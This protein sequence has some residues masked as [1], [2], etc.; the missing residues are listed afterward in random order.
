MSTSDTPSTKYS[1]I[2]WNDIDRDTARK[3]I[4]E[5]IEKQGIDMKRVREI[6]R[7]SQQTDSFNVWY[8]DTTKHSEIVLTTPPTPAEPEKQVTEYT[9]EYKTT[10]FCPRCRNKVNV[11]LAYSSDKDPV[12]PVLTRV[13]TQYR[14][15]QRDATLDVRAVAEQKHQCY[16]LFTRYPTGTIVSGRYI[17][18][19]DIHGTGNRVAVI[20]VMGSD[21]K[22]YVANS[23]NAIPEHCLVVE[24]VLKEGEPDDQA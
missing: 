8:W 5:N 13:G 3:I 2:N 6:K 19:P 18:G 17:P 20:A 4:A 22:W 12:N 24:E 21:R 16:P 7:I 10:L 23:G 1:W 11:T 15:Q 14:I 9:D